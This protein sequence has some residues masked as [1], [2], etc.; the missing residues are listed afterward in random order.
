MER[1]RLEAAI[2]DALSFGFGQASQVAG[3]EELKATEELL[4]RVIA[5]EAALGSSTASLREVEIRAAVAD[6]ASFGYGDAN[7]QPPVAG[8]AVVEAAKVRGRIT[9]AP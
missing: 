8:V 3:F 5:C 2:A 4:K 9:S 6:A 7:A 1:E